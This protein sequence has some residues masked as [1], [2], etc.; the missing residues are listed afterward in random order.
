MTA[1]V[2]DVTRFLWLL[3]LGA[4]A[5]LAFLAHTFSP[6]VR[7][8]DPR[9]VV[10]AQILFAI[11]AWRCLF[12]N[13]YVNHIVLHDTV[14][15]STLVTRVL[16]TAV[17]VAWIAQFAHVLRLANVAESGWVT[18]AAGWM[19]AQ[20]VVSQGF[21]WAAIATGRVALYFY[22][23]L[24]WAV[25][26]ALNTL[27]SGFLLAS[28]GEAGGLATLLRFNLLFGVFYLPWQMFHLRSLRREARGE[29]TSAEPVR[30]RLARALHERNR[31]TDADSW[32]GW[33]GLTWMTAYWATLIPFWVFTVVRVTAT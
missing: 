22:E 23:E 24:G 26:F 6:A 1:G 2:R 17:E 31:A 21:V 4:V 33:I 15:S 25:I 20:V 16:A 8:A 27:A 5:N 29:P 19:V 11:S 12:P 30:G 13:R 28:G 3:K 7:A 9:I 10:P 32:G 18:F 14:L